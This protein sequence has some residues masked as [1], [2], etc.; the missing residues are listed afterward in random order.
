MI[1]SVSTK[2]LYYLRKFGEYYK[3]YFQIKI[4]DSSFCL[5]KYKNCIILYLYRRQ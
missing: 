1:T 3:D 4:A 2:V 5:V